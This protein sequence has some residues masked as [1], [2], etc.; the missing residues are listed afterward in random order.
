MYRLAAHMGIVDVFRLLEELSPEQ[1]DEWI[2]YDELEPLGHIRLQ[3]Q[4]ARLGT[5]LAAADGANFAEKLFLPWHRDTGTDEPQ[6]AV[7]MQAQLAKLG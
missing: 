1:V 7:E 2:A 6:S 3:E 4:L 5:I